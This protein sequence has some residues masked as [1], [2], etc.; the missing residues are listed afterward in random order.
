[1]KQLQTTIPYIV[2]K[3]IYENYI[4][5]NIIFMPRFLAMAKYESTE[6]YGEA[7]MELWVENE[8]GACAINTVPNIAVFRKHK[9]NTCIIFISS[10]VLL[11][12]NSQ[13]LSTAL[14]HCIPYLVLG[15][16]HSDPYSW[17]YIPKKQTSFPLICWKA[18]IALDIYGYDFGISLPSSTNLS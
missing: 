2:P 9:Y 11:N 6:G 16:G 1:M 7:H 3:N 5:Q 8:E 14:F 13:S 4:R 10:T 15:S 17:T 12:F 18:N